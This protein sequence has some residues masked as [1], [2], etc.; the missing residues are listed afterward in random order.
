M[1]SVDRVNG[2]K[3]PGSEMESSTNE[4]SQGNYKAEADST[5]GISHAETVNCSSFLIEHCPFKDTTQSYSYSSED[6]FE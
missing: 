4:S 5:H 1:K 2:N 6:E 3:D